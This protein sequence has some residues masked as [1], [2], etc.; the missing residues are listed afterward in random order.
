MTPWKQYEGQRL[1]ETFPLHRYLGGDDNH[2]VFLTEYRDAAPQKAAI[3]LILGDPQRTESQLHRWNLAANLSHPHLIRIFTMGRSHLNDSPLIYLV[4]EYADENL[5]E[6]IP[7]RPLAAGEARE[8]LKP[9]LSA[10]AYLHGQGFSHGHLTPANILAVDDGLKISSDNVRRIGDPTD[11]RTPNASN[12]PEIEGITPAG[13]VWSLGMTLVEALT[14][15]APA[16]PMNGHD[17]VVPETLPDPFLDIARHCLR[18]DP[19]SRWT[20]AE[21]RERL[22]LVEASSTGPSV[23]KTS[24]SSRRWLF[25]FAAVVVLAVLA[26]AVVPRVLKRRPATP[27]VSEVPP[28][29]P[30]QQVEP[31]Q[32]SQPKQQ[33]ELPRSKPTRPPYE[34]GP[35]KVVHQVL[36]VVPSRARRTIQGKVR[37]SVRVYVDP[38]GRVALAKLDAPAPSKYFAQRALEAARQWKFSS[39]EASNREARDQWILRFEFFRTDTKVVPVHSTPRRD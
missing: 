5:G 2:A 32:E 12:P 34:V 24:T 31:K 28:V 13:D 26:I 9:V 19:A 29:Q 27:P 18:S 39:V 23:V 36:P 22:G 25:V 33:A 30:K 35:R 16:R 14:Q 7:T 3:K 15:H 4:M 8:M 11:S 21:I 37:V 1:N 38:S 6:V 17:P 10:L 20:V